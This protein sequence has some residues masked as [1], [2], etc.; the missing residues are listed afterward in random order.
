MNCDRRNREVKQNLWQVRK[1]LPAQQA[2]NYRRGPAQHHQ[3]R[4]GEVYQSDQYEKVVDREGSTIGGHTDAQ[5]GGQCRHDEVG[6]ESRRIR[7]VKR[8]EINP[9]ACGANSNRRA[10]EYAHFG[11]RPQL[12]DRLARLE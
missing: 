12:L 6:Q 1:A 9:Q 8:N 4:K 10:E 5:P 7:R 2:L 3:L 11:R